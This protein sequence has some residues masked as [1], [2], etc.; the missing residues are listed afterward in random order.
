MASVIAALTL[1]ADAWCKRDT[2][3]SHR[4]KKVKP[5]YTLNISTSCVFDFD[6]ISFL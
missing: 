4:S 3:G 1:D 6:F 5:C 2:K